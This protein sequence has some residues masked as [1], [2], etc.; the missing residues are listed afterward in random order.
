MVVN[1]RGCPAVEENLHNIDPN[2]TS[3][4][5]A[6]TQGYRVVHVA[7]ANILTPNIFKYPP[8]PV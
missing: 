7:S 8:H 4:S 6:A 3:D 1:R 2:R 5:A